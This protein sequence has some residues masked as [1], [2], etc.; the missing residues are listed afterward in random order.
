MPRGLSTHILD[1]LD[2]VRGGHD[3]N[4]QRGAV[5]IN[6][7]TERTAV[8]NSTGGGGGGWRDLLSGWEILW[9]EE[10]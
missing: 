9:I 5:I 2:W 1:S 6:A 3:A 7:L 10:L 4:V 8:G